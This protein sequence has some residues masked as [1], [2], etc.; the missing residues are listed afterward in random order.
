[1]DVITI[2][3]KIKAMNLLIIKNENE[4][5]DLLEWIDMQFDLKVI[6]ESEEGKKLQVALLLIKQYENENYAIPI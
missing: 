3:F 5:Q 2:K 4:Y 1:M 6:P